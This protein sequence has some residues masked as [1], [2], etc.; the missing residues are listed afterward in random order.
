[1]TRRNS[2]QR[3]GYDA[4]IV[5]YATSRKKVISDLI[6]P[7]SPLHQFAFSI[8][9]ASKPALKGVE[10][11]MQVAVILNFAFSVATFG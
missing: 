2:T 9:T 5:H 7:R 11:C 8:A 3:E 10:V 6:I 4:R 1:M